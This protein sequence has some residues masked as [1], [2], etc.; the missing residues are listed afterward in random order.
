MPAPTWLI[1]PILPSGGLVGLY[2]QPGAGKSFLAI[3]L[4]LCVATGTPWH[5]H[6]IHQ[7]YVVYVSAEG[8]TGIG[9][10]V[11]AWLQTHALD[12]VT[13]HMAWLIESIPIYT[14]SEQMAILLNRIVEEMQVHPSLIVIDTLARCFD[15]DENQQEDMGRFIAG[16]DTLRHEFGATILVVHHTRRDGE[17]ER[18]STAFRGAADAMLSM[19]EDDGRMVVS[20][21]KQKDAEEFADIR[22]ELIP[23]DGTDSCI[24]GD[25][26][27]ESEKE[28]KALEILT[29]LQEIGP[30][31]WEGW[32]SSTELPKTTFHRHFMELQ[33]KGLIVKENHQWRALH[34]G[35]FHDPKWHK[36]R[37]SKEKS[38]VA[39][40]VGDIP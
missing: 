6:E 34:E 17:N 22:L 4:A 12:A 20:C 19:T 5:G 37:I 23:V 3:D 38:I 1:E 32:L 14:D 13:P 9:K 36:T 8:G 35:E 25:D 33:K 24:I 21:N 27:A 31:T 40:P 2:G 18:G 29:I 15:G 11:R 16:V 28:R 39:V 10:R 7:G 30:C 26:Q